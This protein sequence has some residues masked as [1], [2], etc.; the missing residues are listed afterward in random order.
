MAT[1]VG[2]RIGGRPWPWNHEKTIAGTIAFVVCGG[3]GAVALAC[4]TRPAI[5]PLP[6][7]RFE[8]AAPLAAAVVASLVETIP[9]RLDDNVSVP[10]TAAAILWLASLVTPAALDASG[11][12]IL[13]ALP[14]AVGVNVI[15][16]WAGHRARTVSMSGAIV[17]AAIG[18]AIYAA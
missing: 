9:V 14:W 15:V 18:V 6:S 10:A 1:L 3:L 4:W 8:I 17:G 11:R 13:A 5:V 12:A 16:A 2:R 7:W